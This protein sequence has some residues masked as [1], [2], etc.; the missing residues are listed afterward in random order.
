MPA[1]YRK[2]VS[3]RQG[4]GLVNTLINKLPFEL[5]LPG[6]YQYC[7]PGTRL[8]ERLSRGDPGINKLD[9]ACREHDIAYARYKDDVGERHKADQILAKKAFERVKAS[10]ASLGERASALGVAATMKAKVKLGMGSKKRKQ[11]GGACSTFGNVSKKALTQLKKIVERKNVDVNKASKVAFKAINR[12]KNKN[13]IKVP[14]IIKV[15]KTGGILPLIPIFAAL[16]A[17]GALSGGAAAIAKTVKDTDAAKKEL[18][19][20]QRH[21]KTMESIALGKG[22]YLRPYK[23]GYGLAINAPPSKN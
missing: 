1:R 16:S 9:Q 13:K 17:L 22:L 23:K 3:L 21:N 19:E 10:N 14:R 6:G 11:R 4:A 5:H 12:I 20:A 8:T 2:A 18:S 15:P 7:G